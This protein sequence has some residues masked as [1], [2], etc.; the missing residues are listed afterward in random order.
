[1]TNKDKANVL[2]VIKYIS[3]EIYQYALVLYN[4]ISNRPNPKAGDK[5]EYGEKVIVFEKVMLDGE[6]KSGVAFDYIFHEEGD[7]NNKIIIHSINSITDENY[8]LNINDM[9]DMYGFWKYTYPI[10]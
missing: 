7:E 10:Y 6:F 8:I 2:D 4:D 5:Y 3:P 9:K 1:M